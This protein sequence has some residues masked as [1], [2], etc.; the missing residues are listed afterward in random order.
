MQ[1][2][3]LDPQ[4]LCHLLVDQSATYAIVF[5]DADRKIR[6]WNSGAEKLFGYTAAEMIGRDG[7]LLFVPEDV[8]AGVP[9]Q[10]A[11]TATSTGSAEDRRWKIRKDGSRFFADGIMVSLHGEGNTIVGFA[12]II[13][14]ATHE[15]H[16]HDQRTA[17]ERQLRLIV[18]S[19]HDYAIYMLDTEGRLR[20]WSRGAQRIKGYSA[21]EVIGRNF[22]IFYPPAD[23]ARGKPQRQ[24]E[25]AAEDGTYEDESIHVRK[26]GSH[27]WA[28]V[29]LSAIRDEEGHLLGFVNLT[30][31]VSEQ[32]RIED[33]ARFLAE[34]SQL[35]ASSIEYE[36]TLRRIARVAVSRIA[37]W[38]AVDLL[39][40]DGRS[41][42]RVAVEHVDP[43]KV[44]A[45]KAL[46]ERYP[47]DPAAAG[48]GE[49]VR[50]RRT[51]FYPEI[52]AEMLRQSTSDEEHLRLL[53]DLGLRSAI[54]TPLVAADAV[55][56][57][58]VF[59]TSGDRRL[60]DDDVTIAEDIA[61]RAAVAIQNAQLY[62]EAQEANRA[63]D[64]FL[65]TVSHELRTPMTAVLGWSKLLRVE[66]DPT[67]IAEAVVAIERS[68]S[69]Q[70]QLIDDILDVARIRVGKL[71]VR[72]G[73][74]NLAD[75]V[76]GA[77]DTVRLTAEVKDVRLRVEM[78]R[79][80]V[81]IRG[82]AQRLQQVIWNLLTNAV[83]F[84]PEGGRVDVVLEV[85]D[86]MARI[87]VHDTGPGIAPDFLPHL[88]ERFRQAEM[89]QRRSHGG[90][91]LGLSIAQH[92]VNAH[93]GTI[94]AE[95][96]GEGQG[97]TFIV[98]LSLLEESAPSAQPRGRRAGDKPLS[99]QGISVLIVED[100][101][102]TLQFLCR[103]LERAGADARS[104]SS[105]DEALAL[106]NAAVPD[107]VV[108]DIAMPE[109]TG[110]DLV[111]AIRAS[112]PD[113]PVIAV[114]ASGGAGDRDRAL[115]SGF[116]QYLRK[117]VEPHT[118]IRSVYAA[119]RK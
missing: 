63:K 47:N 49:A 37:D 33:R 64:E 53:S 43:A 94:R 29:A 11:E 4:Y 117:P 46:Q 66:T 95:S 10:E 19:I 93:G 15:K 77:V 97:A 108:S 57:T 80:V 70:A 72:F 107:V 28:S 89:T 105:V 16:G 118:L 8:R 44:A 34:A 1:G 32:K 98:E 116:D 86:R 27:F 78:D 41:V 85:I 83:K 103:A 91:G 20:T 42:T 9:Q 114:T 99:L 60:T 14:D 82:D 119:V 61:A 71:Q 36:E 65:A 101:P 76:A 59:V 62:R 111:R 58:I 115:S 81:L 30:H 55:L 6:H 104:A 90:L 92:I 5:F 51:V 84:T 35:L 40:E 106:F 24:L 26:D 22:E 87:V 74:V 39:S 52:N 54:V 56:G 100:D 68:A 88:F 21:E 79:R 109:K 69:A 23:I 48:I 45:A 31:D 102:D 96:P 7:A 13:R 73:A 50:D 38:C 25:I 112:H 2:P 75:V 17:T 3:Q 18:D 113:T 67:V 110:Y 12:K